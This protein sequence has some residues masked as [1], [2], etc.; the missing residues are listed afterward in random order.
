[1]KLMKYRPLVEKL[2]DRTLPLHHAA[3]YAQMYQYIPYP[4][5][6]SPFLIHHLS[7]LVSSSYLV[8]MCRAAASA[9]SSSKFLSKSIPS[10]SSKLPS[11]PSDH[12]SL[13]DSYS[14]SEDSESET[15]QLTPPV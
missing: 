6:G 1:M 2:R 12:S 13:S 4:A 3:L 7:C 14:E 9:L 5:S 8:S 10:S 15:R 11:L